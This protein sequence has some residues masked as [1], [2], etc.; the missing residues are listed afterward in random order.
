MSVCLAPLLVG[1]NADLNSGAEDATCHYQL[2]L[3]LL[4]PSERVILKVIPAIYTRRLPLHGND[5][6]VRLRLFCYTGCKGKTDGKMLTF[7]MLLIY[8]QCLAP[9][10]SVVRGVSL[11]TSAN[12]AA[13]AA[14]FSTWLHSAIEVK[15]TLSMSHLK[16]DR[17]SLNMVP[18]IQ[19]WKSGHTWI[20]R[21][22]YHI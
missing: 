4:I 6:L 19:I 9:L 18:W 3:L 20:H 8:H 17:N 21:L 10:H 22:R 5:L 15:P 12:W 1:K 14:K 11:T 16:I 2:W 13:L 7:H